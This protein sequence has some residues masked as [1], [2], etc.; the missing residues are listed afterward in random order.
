MNGH[1]TSCEIG[2]KL[3]WSLRLLVGRIANEEDTTWE[4]KS[5]RQRSRCRSGSN[6]RRVAK[7]Y[8]NIRQS[9]W[10]ETHKLGLRAA[11]FLPASAYFSRHRRRRVASDEIWRLPHEPPLMPVTA[12]LI[13]ETSSQSACKSRKVK[14]MWSRI[15]DS[16]WNDVTKILWDKN[17]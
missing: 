16:A 1:E 8:F 5:K 6:E 13:A 14:I 17:V 2:S 4:R 15:C 10:L 3:R 12:I 9:P 11:L 7:K